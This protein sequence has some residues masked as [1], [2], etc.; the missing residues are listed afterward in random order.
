[1]HNTALNEHF[2]DIM[3]KIKAATPKVNL[4]Q[5][6]SSKREHCTVSEEE[7]L[8]LLKINQMSHTHLDYQGLTK[9][10]LIMC[11]KERKILKS[12]QFLRKCE[13]NGAWSKHDSFF[14]M[15]YGQIGFQK[16]KS[17][18]QEFTK[19][20]DDSI[21]VK[22]KKPKIL[23]SIIRVPKNFDKILSSTKSAS[24]LNQQKSTVVV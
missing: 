20:Q 15:R 23:K 11:G 2:I 18:K 17:P 12:Q 6:Q 3:N 13:G 10:V 4:N 7:D 19:S 21:L 24:V 9:K 16:I 22:S 1:M 8:N 14:D 5:S